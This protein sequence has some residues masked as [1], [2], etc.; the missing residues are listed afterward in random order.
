MEKVK[1][2][3][4]TEAQINYDVYN[5]LNLINEKLGECYINEGFNPFGDDF[6]LREEFII[7]RYNNSRQQKEINSPVFVSQGVKAT[8]TALEN[9]IKNLNNCLGIIDN[10]SSDYMLNE[11]LKK[12]YNKIKQFLECRIKLSGVFIDKLKTD[13]NTFKMYKELLAID[14]SL[15]E[16]FDESYNEQFNAQVAINAYLEFIKANTIDIKQKLEDKKLIERARAIIEDNMKRASYEKLQEHLNNKQEDQLSTTP[17]I[18]DEIK[19]KQKNAEQK[20]Q[21]QEHDIER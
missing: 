6:K 14:Y 19:I 9:S 8:R 7:E 17:N 1:F 11:H 16:Y 12:Q 20:N 13:K 3:K 10:M 4:L 15:A 18:L 21:K 5:G 2:E